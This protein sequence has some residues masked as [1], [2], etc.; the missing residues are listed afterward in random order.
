WSYNLLP[1]SA[2]ALFRRLS[3]FAGGWTVEGA[4]GVV[5]ARDLLDDLGRLVEASLVVREPGQ[6]R[7]RMLEPV[8]EYAADVLIASG[9]DDT[10]RD[11][12]AAF[13]HT[14]AVDA[15]SGLMAG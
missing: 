2:Q 9:E 3:V 10:V 12:H 4:E 15:E 7:Y 5:S 8:R 11:Q 6:D 13:Y 14:L 1:G